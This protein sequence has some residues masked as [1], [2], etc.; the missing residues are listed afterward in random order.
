MKV[1]PDTHVMLVM[2]E[3]M[4]WY[5]VAQ[6]YFQ[7]FSTSLVKTPDGGIIVVYGNANFSSYTTQ[8]DRLGYIN[9][10]LLNGLGWLYQ[11]VERQKGEPGFDANWPGTEQALIIKLMFKLRLIQLSGS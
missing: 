6:D 5:G 9:M 4:G 3:G 1:G 2:A 10:D 11:P 7:G 8:E